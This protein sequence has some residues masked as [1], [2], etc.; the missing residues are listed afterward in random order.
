MK[1][2]L[3]RADLQREYGLGRDM[4]ISIIRLLPNSQIGR[5][6]YIRTEDFEAFLAAGI[7]KGADLNASVKSM[8]SGEALAWIALERSKGAAHDAR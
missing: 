5:S 6:R 2:I 3:S 4:A 8:T 1:A 7:S